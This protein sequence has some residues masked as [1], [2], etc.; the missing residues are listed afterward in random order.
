MK[1]V[2]I[3]LDD[4]KVVPIDLRELLLCEYMQKI[5]LWFD[6]D[7][8]PDSYKEL[9]PVFKELSQ[10]FGRRLTLQ[11]KEQIYTGS[12]EDWPQHVADD[13]KKFLKDFIDGRE[14]RMIYGPT[15]EE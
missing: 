8:N 9:V 2:H 5:C 11:M 3:Q 12:I 6:H 7:W 14:A 13:G 4:P 15:E 10:K 1:N